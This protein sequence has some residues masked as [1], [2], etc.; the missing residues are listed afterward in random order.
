MAFNLG[1]AS[2]P[3]V[4][5]LY[6]VLPADNAFLDPS[7]AGEW[8]SEKT[9][10]VWNFFQPERPGVDDGEEYP[11]FLTIT[12]KE[13]RESLYYVDLDK[14]GSVT[15]LQVY[16]AYNYSGEA[17]DQLYLEH[18]YSLP[19]HRI[20]RV[21]RPGQDLYLKEIDSRRM[22]RKLR[23]SGAAVDHRVLKGRLVLMGQSGP[24]RE[25]LLGE[26]GGRENLWARKALRLV[27]VKHGSEN[28]PG[29]NG[30]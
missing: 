6:P 13:G 17:I 30:P 19:L 11:W 28:D 27:R 1:C 10:E 12:G 8:H 16:P 4:V 7:I 3:P 15:V 14:V 29:G 26:T 22:A 5:S 18:F 9:G 23:N 2:A 21:E 24:I 20:Y 25:V